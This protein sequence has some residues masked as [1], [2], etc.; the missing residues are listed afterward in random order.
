MDD[1]TIATMNDAEFDAL[2][3]RF[4]ERGEDQMTPRTFRQVMAEDAEQRSQPE[5]EL[6]GRVVNGE[7]IFDLPAPL[8][9]GAHTLYAG[10]TKIKLTAGGKCL[11]VSS[12]SERPGSILERSDDSP[13]QSRDH[14]RS[15]PRRFGKGDLFDRYVFCESGSS[16][17]T[18]TN[19]SGTAKRSR[20]AE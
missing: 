10:D 3:D 1:K 5:M 14:C 19:A 9:V 7:I 2:V 13:L 11:G 20:L 16:S 4:I 18:F 15:D 12:R 17:G 8:P 6:S